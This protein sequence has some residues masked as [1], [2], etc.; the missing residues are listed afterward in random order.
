[1]TRVHEPD[2]AVKPPNKPRTAPNERTFDRGHR[3][4]LSA[5]QGPPR[6]SNEAP[7]VSTVW[8]TLAGVVAGTLLGFGSSQVAYRWQRADQRDDARRTSLDETRRRLLLAY[9]QLKNGPHGAGMIDAAFG[10][11]TASALSNSLVRSGVLRLDEAVDQASR[12]RQALVSSQTHDALNEVND[13]VAK[14]AAEL[15]ALEAH[16][17]WWQR[18]PSAHSG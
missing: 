2:K 12:I 6:A 7:T 13:L 8:E 14:V 9:Q 5:L 11:S 16:R 1:M 4:P 15:R 10:A 17:H 18:R 3:N